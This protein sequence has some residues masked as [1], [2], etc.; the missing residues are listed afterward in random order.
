MPGFA[1]QDFLSLVLTGTAHTPNPSTL[2][3][4]LILSLGSMSFQ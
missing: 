3:H 1:F 4:T 2:K